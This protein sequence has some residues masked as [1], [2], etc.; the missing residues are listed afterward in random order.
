MVDRVKAS[1]RDDDRA[2]FRGSPVSQTFDAPV[3]AAPTTKT[4]QFMSGV[5]AD[6]EGRRHSEAAHCSACCPDCTEQAASQ[7]NHAELRGDPGMVG[8]IASRLIEGPNG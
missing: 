5:L 1:R 3:Q 4:D 2:D 8:V 7:W 6:P